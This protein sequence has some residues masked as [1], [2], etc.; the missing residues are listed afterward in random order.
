MGIVGEFVSRWMEGAEDEVRVWLADDAEWALVTA[1]DDVAEGAIPWPPVE[2]ERAEIL[3]IVTHGK[4][5]AC[6]GYLIRA[7]RRVDFCHF[8]QFVNTAKT[9]KISEVR[10]YV[11]S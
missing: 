3:S 11:S 9:A 7:D 8:L 6:D 5:A 4:L 1:A 2:A 10:T